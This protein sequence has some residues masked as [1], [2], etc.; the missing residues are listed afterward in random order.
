MSIDLVVA[1]IS[2][3][4]ALVNAGGGYRDVRT[5]GTICL[6]YCVYHPG[7]RERGGTDR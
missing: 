2:I 3:G 1:G 4:I 6:E 5:H 7:R